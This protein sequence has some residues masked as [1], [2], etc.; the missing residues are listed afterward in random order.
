MTQYWNI[1][2]FINLLYIKIYSIEYKVFQ[3]DWYT[4]PTVNHAIEVYEH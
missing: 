2:F 3:L 4:V 1:L